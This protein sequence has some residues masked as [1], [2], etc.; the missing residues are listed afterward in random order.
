MREA[1]SL[2]VIRELLDQGARV[3]AHDP[4]AMHEAKR[5]F[6]DRISLVESPYEACTGADALLILTEWSTYQRPNFEA[7]RRLLRSPLVIDGRNIYNPDRM[8]AAGFVYHSIGRATAR[9]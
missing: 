2:T 9:P 5:I 3:V 7:I 6:G 4:E 1:P 8:C